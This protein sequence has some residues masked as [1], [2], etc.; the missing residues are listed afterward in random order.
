MLLYLRY[1]DMIL[2]VPG[3]FLV[4][5]LCNQ[6]EWLGF[7]R[8][9][10]PALRN[11]PIYALPLTTCMLR[12]RSNKSPFVSGTSL[13][14]KRTHLWGNYFLKNSSKSFADS[15]RNSVCWM[16]SL[17]CIHLC[18]LSKELS[19]LTS[20]LWTS[21]LF[22]HFNHSWSW[23]SLDFYGTRFRPWFS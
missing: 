23:S 3:N 11:T 12:Y 18:K 17:L 4:F 1:Y 20:F 9:L 10:H 21:V 15:S 19:A 13:I 16:S 7:H 22:R 8:L 6:W 5:A 2:K 14:Q